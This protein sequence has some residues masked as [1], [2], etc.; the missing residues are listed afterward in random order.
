MQI[1]FPRAQQAI[2]NDL[3]RDIPKLYDFIVADN[4]FEVISGKLEG[5]YAWIA[6]NYVLDKFSHG[7]SG[8]YYLLGT[9][10][11]S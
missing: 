1:F 11:K 2:L 9:Y 8:V 3:L 7:E 5:L 10:S 6:V 4:N